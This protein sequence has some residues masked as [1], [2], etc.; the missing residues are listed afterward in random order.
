M[1]PADFVSAAGRVFQIF[2]QRTQ[3][4]GNISY[5][6]ETE[7]HRYFVKTAGS[8]VDSAPALSHP[9]RVRLLRNVVRLHQLVHHPTLVPLL[10]VVESPQGPM[11]V[12]EWTNGKLLGAPAEL[13]SDPST[14]YVRF[15]RLPVDR[16]IAALTDVIDLH[17]VLASRS[18]V[19]VDF[20]DGSLMYDFEA[21]RIRVIDLDSY[22]PGRFLNRMGRMF[23][24]TRL[25]SR[26]S[27]LLNEP[28]GGC[29]RI[30]TRPWLHSARLLSKLRIE[31]GPYE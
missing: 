30:V 29:P 2:D 20:Y 9:D 3:D 24:S 21:S 1:S 13:R 10:N 26:S 27:T 28:S 19:A 7:S 12:F 23:G 22:T 25:M 6:V 31:A 16:I 4:S 15:R 17:C 18:Y 11:L 5:G 8:Q 14:A